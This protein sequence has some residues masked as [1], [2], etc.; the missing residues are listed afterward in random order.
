MKK[1]YIV[2]KS[3]ESFKH[4]KSNIYKYECLTDGSLPDRWFFETEQDG[5]NFIKS[6][7]LNYNNDSTCYYL[8]TL[9]LFEYDEEL[10]EIKS[11]DGAIYTTSI[12]KKII[13]EEQN[14]NLIY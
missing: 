4:V 8:E 3:E 10:E 5:I 9:D 6:Y 2:I 12:D 13:E 14:I 7:K 11:D 1:K